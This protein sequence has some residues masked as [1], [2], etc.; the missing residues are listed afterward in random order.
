LSAVGE[1]YTDFDAACRTLA[2]ATR[3][4]ERAGD[5]FVIE[6][7]HALQGIIM[8][9]RDRHA[10][11]ESLLQSAIEGLL[12]RHRGVAATALGYQACGALYTGEFARAQQLAEQAV[13]VAEPLGDYLRV[14]ST[15]SVL[16]LVVGHAG[17]LDAGFEV[18]RPVLRLIEGAENDVF[19]PGLARAMGSL[20]LWRGEPEQA[21]RWFERE[22]RS[23]DRGIET[24]LAAHA[25]PGHAAALA[26]L[27]RLDQAQ[28][29]L[30]T[31]LRVARRLGMPRVIADCF[32]QQAHLTAAA[33]PDRAI[34]LHHEALALRVEYGLRTFW[35]D[36]LDALA[37]LA[38]ASIDTVR[39]LAATDAAR[40]ALG[41]PRDTARQARHAA[42]T[43]ALRQRLASAFDAAWTEGARMRLDEAV[44]YV[45]RSRG[46]RRRPTVGWASLT[47]TEL[48][49]VRCVVDGLNNPE[50]GSRLFMSRGTVKTHLSH[51]FAKLGVTNRTELAMFA[52]ARLAATESA[53]T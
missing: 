5:A 35:V 47:P 49:V 39:V 22:A 13:R 31:G 16:A 8:H 44:A 23:T 33:D 34:D 20:H 9:L 30:D 27:S 14:G 21:A 11:A 37:A 18:M 50:I 4:A 53:R 6:G 2:D 43:G 40:G 32:E 45:R 36:S 29:A 3:A 52:G 51:V 25:L 26:A 28:A 7:A 38:D 17:H 12:R 41:Y 10:E 48:D 15:R 42:K 19:V 1:F 24:F 46:T